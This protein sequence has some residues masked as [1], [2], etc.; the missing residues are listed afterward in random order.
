MKLS[1]QIM[2]L[3][4]EA[5]P[6]SPGDENTFDELLRKSGIQKAA[7]KEPRKR[8]FNRKSPKKRKPKYFKIRKI[9]NEHLPELFKSSQPDQIDD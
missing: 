3:W 7:R 5:R 2:D 1:G 6:P 9:T 4:R 8:G